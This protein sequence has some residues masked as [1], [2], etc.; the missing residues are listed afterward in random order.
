MATTIANPSIQEVL[1]WS[2]FQL[3][4][5]ETAIETID[6]TI[7]IFRVKSSNAPKNIFKNPLISGFGGSLSPY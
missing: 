2:V 1:L 4:P 7:K 5:T 3:V 6:E